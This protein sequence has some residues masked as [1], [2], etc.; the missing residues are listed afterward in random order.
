MDFRVLGP[1]E[2]VDGDRP[3]DLGG[4]RQRALLA[5]LLTRANQVVPRD[6]LIDALFGEEP[7]EAARNL[8]QV[9]VSRLR[10]A[11][12]PGR[13]RRSGGSIIVTRA[14]GYLVQLES[15]HLDLHRFERLA[16]DGRRALATGEAEQAAERFREAL[17]LWRGPALADFAFEEFAAGEST[18][19]DE[20]RLAVVEDRIEADLARGLDATLIGELQGLV[21][22]HPLRERPRGQLMLALYRA[23]RQAEALDVYQE[24]R[25][26]LVEELGL[27]PGST[28][29]EL[30][31]AMLQQDPALV[32]GKSPAAAP[33][34][35]A[36]RHILVVSDAADDALEV[37]TVAE[38]LA[39][40]SEPRE[41]IL[42]QL[43]RDPAE[44]RRA[45]S[46]LNDERAGLADRG[47]RARSTAFTTADWAADVLRLA[48]EQEIE[49]L[50]L[51]R[52]PEDDRE[53][54]AGELGR[55]LDEAPCDVVL[56]IGEGLLASGAVLV[57]FG[58]ADHDWAALELGAWLARASGR[59]LLLLGPLAKPEGGARDASR[60]LAQA[61]LIVQRFLDVAA[62]P[63][64]TPPG[65]DGIVEAA[66]EAGIV[67]AGLSSRWRQEGIGEVR[68]EIVR[69]VAQPVLLVRRG[70][71]PGGL[72]P[73]AT[74][75]RFSWSL[76][77]ASGTEASGE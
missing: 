7:R 58:G 52:F 62:E 54:A 68:R 57:P 12:E 19:L 28:L 32:L 27:E 5:I 26:L 14:P 29:R 4:P 18:R 67:V 21:A 69:R 35:A 1:L 59:P 31:R 33:E 71:R 70:I 34:T 15:D 17:A 22:E 42:A 3:V 38:A 30:E 49:L 6:T 25:R 50:L 65:V 47:L 11:L 36:V 61:S 74:L 55:V 76:R 40:A 41:L 77:E 51:S 20:L 75:T 9:Y 66:S 45:A 39:A 46:R 56:H 24:G 64:L 44:L 2:V 53:V 73:T 72:A 43:V 10:K 23:G 8:L 13:D 60:L 37:L 48:N 63:L 16:E